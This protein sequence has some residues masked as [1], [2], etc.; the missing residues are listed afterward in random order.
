MSA[1]LRPLGDFFPFYEREGSHAQDRR[2][3]RLLRAA[4]DNNSGYT[5]LVLLLMGYRTSLI[6][7]SS[8]RIE[9]L[10]RNLPNKYLGI[11]P[12]PTEER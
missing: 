5:F 3:M 4:D 1:R 8:P 12:I 6:T 10:T 9:F 11:C 2:M 7:P